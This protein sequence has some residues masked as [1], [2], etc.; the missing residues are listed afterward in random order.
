MSASGKHV[1]QADM[2]L[3]AVIGLGQRLAVDDRDHLRDAGLDA[4]VV[5]AQ[6]EMRG[7]GLIDDPIRDRIG[8]RALESVAHFDAHAPVVLRDQ[9]D[10]AV[11][12][13]LASELPLIGHADAVLLDLLRVGRGHDQHHDLAAL[14][15]LESGELGFDAVHR[16]SP[17]GCR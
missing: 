8:Q 3:P 1:V 10:R 13:T 7:D 11:V 6:F 12:D 15:R 16:V 2:A 14:A 17:T 9:Q 5:V 4:S